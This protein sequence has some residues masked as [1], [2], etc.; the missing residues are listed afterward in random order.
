MPT[1]PPT[2]SSSFA[3]PPLIKMISVG[4]LLSA[5]T[6][7]TAPLCRF[8][9]ILCVQPPEYK[10]STAA[11]MFN[12][13]CW[14]SLL[15]KITFFNIYKDHTDL[16]NAF[17]WA[18]HLW[19]LDLSSNSFLFSS[20]SLCKVCLHLA[21]TQKAIRSDDLKGQF[22][23]KWKFCHRLFM[24]FQIWITFFLFRIQRKV[25]WRMLYNIGPHLLS[26]CGHVSDQPIRRSHI[27]QL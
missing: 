12:Q 5:S 14:K 16:Q 8:T 1:H 7:I 17:G 2:R 11:S 18:E 6:S 3:S 19:N 23:K 10:E 13:R 27:Q 15:Y 9:V 22:T 4:L 25:F 24:S 20:M 26:L 21:I